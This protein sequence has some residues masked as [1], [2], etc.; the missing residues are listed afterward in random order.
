MS[1][2]LEKALS[3]EHF[4]SRY[5]KLCGNIKSKNMKQ[6]CKNNNRTAIFLQALEKAKDVAND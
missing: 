3:S 4:K 6:S 5:E 1:H 2:L